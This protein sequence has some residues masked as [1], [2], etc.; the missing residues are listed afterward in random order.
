GR[1][2]VDE[3]HLSGVRIGQGHRLGSF[4]FGILVDL[5]IAEDDRGLLRA[6]LIADPA[7]AVRGIDLGEISVPVVQD[8]VLT[9]EGDGPAPGRRLTVDTRAVLVSCDL[10]ALAIDDLHPGPLLLVADG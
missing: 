2:E 5:V 3:S 4:Q 8:P 6:G 1:P 9:A 10:L 7:V